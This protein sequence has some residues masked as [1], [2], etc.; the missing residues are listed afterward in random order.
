MNVS[1]SLNTIRL[2]YRPSLC[3][4]HATVSTFNDLPIPISKALAKFNN[5]QEPDIRAVVLGRLLCHAARKCGLQAIPRKSC[6]H[7]IEVD[8]ILS[9]LLS[10][11]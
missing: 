6:L 7:I 9:S 5:G 2:L 3:L 10:N 4:P 8:L 1:A 11:N